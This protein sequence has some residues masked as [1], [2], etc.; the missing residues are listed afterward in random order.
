MSSTLLVHPPSKKWSSTGMTAW[1]KFL[2]MA[3]KVLLAWPVIGA[4]GYTH[5]PPSLSWPCGWLAM[6]A[7]QCLSRKKK[8]TFVCQLCVVARLLS[9]AARTSHSRGQPAGHQMTHFTQWASCCLLHPLPLPPRPL[10]FITGWRG[11][12]R[13][14]A[15]SVEVQNLPGR[16][17]R[18]NVCLIFN[19]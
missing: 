3:L 17:M 10:L 11:S 15:F 16:Q 8:K 14:V 6:L 5:I 9:S 2:P 12:L 19:I 13:R 4:C 7:F 1:V 18:R